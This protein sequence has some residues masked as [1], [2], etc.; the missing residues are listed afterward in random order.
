[1]SWSYNQ[2]HIDEF[3]ESVTEKFENHSCALSLSIQ[4][5]TNMH[6]GHECILSLLAPIACQSERDQL[7][8]TLLRQV[9]MQRMLC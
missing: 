4:N 5:Y 9:M 6:N 3:N 1:M 7:L 2:V 8:T